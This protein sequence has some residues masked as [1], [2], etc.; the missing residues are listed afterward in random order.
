M[1]VIA[2]PLPQ[3]DL[4]RSCVV[5]ASAG[6][7]KT[8][9]LVARIVDVI[10]AGTP[11][12]EIVAVTFTHAAA[13]NMKLRVRHEIEQR[14]ALATDRLV[15]ERLSTAAQT[16][17]RASI[18]TIHGFCA[19]LL[20]HR[21]VEAC[22]DP[23]FEE[24]AQP[25]ALAV[26][27]RV[28]RRWIERRLSAPSPS[29][30][31]ALARLTWL[32]E[33]DAG[34][35]LDLLRSA[36][37]CL[38]EWRD[39]DAPWESRSFDREREI[40]SLLAD[41]AASL[42][43]RRPFGKYELQ[44]MADLVERAARADAAGRRDYDMLESD[45][46]RLP[47]HLRFA[48]PGG[49]WDALHNRIEQFRL[50][51]DAHLAPALRD[52]L[53]EVVGAYDEAKRRAGQLDFL[54]L[55]LCA[56]KLLR[57]DAA[58]ADLQ[59]RYTR[60]FVD[61]FQDTDPLQAEI[62]LLLSA[63]DPG[64]RDWRK[65]SPEPGKLFVVGDPKQSIY[66][67]R[68]ADAHLYRRIQGD[69][70]GRG[71]ARQALSA[72]TRSTAEIQAFVNAAFSGAIPGYL[73]LDGGDPGPANQ[74][75]VVALPMPKPYGGNGKLAKKAIEACSP[76]A[77]AAFVH[78]LVEKSGW[79]VRER[80]T[81][82]R[83]PIRAEHVCILFRRFVNSRGEDLTQDYVR[84]LEARGI[85]HVLVGSKSFHRREEVGTIRTA[86]R[87]IEWLDDELSVFAF[88]RGT[89]FAIPDETLLKFYDRHG[90]FRPFIELPDD[91]DPEF[92]PIQQ[93]FNLLQEL[94]RERNACPVADTIN[95]LLDR[96]RAHAAFAFHRGG[97][98][99]LANVYR[100][101]DLARSFEGSSAA[102]SFRAFIEYLE[103]EHDSSDA[104]E[105]PVLEQQAGGVKLMTAHKA[106]G[107]EFPV[108]ILADLT[109]NLTRND[110]GERYIDS[111]RGLCAQRLM[112]LAPH[113][114][115]D[116]ADE[117]NK[118]EL[119]EAL[120][121]AYVS[122]TRA[123]DLLVVSV[124]GEKPWDEGWLSPLHEALYPLKGHWRQA[125]PAPGCPPFGRTTVLNRPLEERDEVSVQPGL[126]V[127]RCGSHRV[128]W[129]DPCAL[130]LE[131]PDSE[132]LQNED[133]LKG[134]PE[135]IGEGLRKYK[136]WQ[137]RRREVIARGS[138]PSFNVRRAIDAGAAAETDDIAVDVIPL[139][140]IRQRPG[141]RLFG[142]LVHRILERAGG[143]EE[144]A[145]LAAIHGRA[146]GFQDS[147][148][149]AAAE[150]AR[151]A[152]RHPALAGAATATIRR[153]EMPVMARLED[154]T[155][156]EGVVDLAWSDGRSWTVVDYKTDDADRKRYRSQLRLY[157]HALRQATGLPARGIL[158]EI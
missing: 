94:H 39:F 143:E 52:E 92:E 38:A 47:Y 157:A 118:A 75:A 76:D 97:E 27:A 130:E 4:S 127:P 114:L 138:A 147:D 17:D 7:G 53:F 5:E 150:I 48:Q 77:V 70:A 74:P 72:S 152:L 151:A 79:T 87:A 102:T 142:R 13:G 158:L 49:A 30:R 105:A 134:T 128:V 43:P 148:I 1:A 3:F 153:R 20:R 54:D 137:N 82:S 83:V 36:A 65:A 64:E 155:L 117:E 132:G 80:S 154:G 96:T 31:R 85:D 9:A 125:A 129:F 131:T 37:W 103:S 93:A 91:L 33:K 58:R 84:R 122:S 89:L 62:L 50:L 121:V 6:T 123:R 11:V 104:S 90:R 16:L 57:N 126:H 63:S 86:L 23:S 2:S 55:L 99:R 40:D 106:K 133:V 139:E 29:L 67:F 56:R 141:G 45:L 14:R 107:L 8:T 113:E 42:P 32:E 41:A 81:G 25:D 10:A 21:P 35:P 101:A 26:F 110:G 44:P 22:V 51:A 69:L 19:K 78:W 46:L 61:E 136:E 112:K 100:L 71:A 111:E 108:V 95:K 146:L 60:I 109:A 115:L 34:E 12:S 140:G 15:R 18:G 98:R 145:A 119:E 124:I 28:F 66:R 59:R 144:T 73:P 120:R 68:R 24:L 156:V 88:L 149:A 116:H 135:Q